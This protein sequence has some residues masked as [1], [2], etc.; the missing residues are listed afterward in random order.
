MDLS[1]TPLDCNDANPSITLP[2]W[3][4]DND[5]DGDGDINNTFENCEP[6]ENYVPS[7]GDCDD[8]NPEVSSLATEV[9][10]GID[11]DCDELIDIEDS[12]WDSTTGHVVYVDSDGDGRGNV[13]TR[14]EVCCYILDG[15]V[16][17]DGDCQDDDINLNALD[18]DGDGTS[19]CTGDCDDN[20]ALINEQAIEICNGYDD[21]CDGFIDV[22]D[23]NW[24]SSGFYF[25]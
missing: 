14:Q 12:S 10:N 5:G 22:E 1:K 8:T 7:N 13:S 9:C 23:S 24:D 2:L 4:L 25:T 17:L 20:N 18:E 15:Y 16:T 21:D 19:S 11:D 6:P 3:Y